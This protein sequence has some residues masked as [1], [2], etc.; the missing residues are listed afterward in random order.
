MSRSKLAIASIL[1]VTILLA[2]SHVAVLADTSSQ[3]NNSSSGVVSTIENIGDLILLQNPVVTGVSSII[4]S[5][6][7]NNSSGSA[8]VSSCSISLNLLTLN[9]GGLVLCL[10][11]DI[12]S[13]VINLFILLADQFVNFAVSINATANFSG[14]ASNPG[15][16]SQGWALSLGLTNYLFVIGLVVI[17]IGTMLRRSFGK[18]ILPRFI[19]VALLIGFSFTIAMFLIGISNG[20]TKDLINL[21]TNNGVNDVWASLANRFNFTLPA[22]S[23]LV[24]FV[25]ESIVNGLANLLFIIIFGL[26]AVVTLV[27]T[28]I[29]FLYR[30]V[31]LTLLLILLPFACFLS[32]FPIDMA[33]QGQFWEKW[34]KEFTRWIIF[35]PVMA[36]FIYIS[37]AL[38]SGPSM[39]VSSASGLFANI[40]DMIALIGLLLGGLYVANELGIS[41]AG[42]AYKVAKDG[43]AK[44]VPLLVGTAA[45]GGAVLAGSHWLASGGEEVGKKNRAERIASTLAK[46]PGGGIAASR[47]AGVSKADIKKRMDAETAVLD[48]LDDDSVYSRAIANDRIPEHH[49]AAAARL[50]ELAK[51]DLLD[52]LEDEH[53]EVLKNMIRSAKTTGQ[54]EDVLENRPDFAPRFE[55][56]VA[57]TVKGIDDK[58]KLSVKAI[59][60]K[61]VFA[62]LSEDAMKQI[63]SK[64]T[65]K[66]KGAVKVMVTNNAAANPEVR[67]VIELEEKAKGFDKASEKTLKEFDDS[68]KKALKDFDA[69]VKEELNK[70]PETLDFDNKL[71]AAIQANNTAYINMLNEQK[72]NALKAIKMTSTDRDALENK[73]DADRKALETKLDADKKTLNSKLKDERDKLTDFEKSI[74]LHYKAVTENPAWQQKQR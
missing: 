24:P 32:I 46:I 74:A 62:S 73:L 43:V 45:V 18:E 1:V 7:S 65:Y 53:P 4:S 59:N 15:L 17:A 36:F 33:G 37:F 34:V 6:T 50:N 64:G 19:V 13:A 39:V 3:P 41:G 12:V 2:T 29:M 47:I 28:A 51:R 26:I 16:A 21:A 25:G 56:D 54:Y 61:E 22:N 63:A 14:T 66:Q 8:P 40:G 67:H 31:A 48:N 68:K 27:A 57:D 10:L 71:K 23:S 44:G 42:F 30:Y 35:G 49:A 9:V 52:K 55:E 58:S 72:D 60:N 20:L 38:L 70:H 11:Q 5:L 69:A